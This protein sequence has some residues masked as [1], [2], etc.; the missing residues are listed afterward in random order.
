MFVA[1][2]PAVVWFLATLYM[3]IRLPKVFQPIEMPVPLFPWW[4]SFGVL[5]TT[6]LI[7]KTSC[8]E[9]GTGKNAGVQARGETQLAAS[10]LHARRARM[11]ARF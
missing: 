1:L 10:P 11:E 7:G 9:G 2:F 5:S 6:F 8:L 3:H 4:P